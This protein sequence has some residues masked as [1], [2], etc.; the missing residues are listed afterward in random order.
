MYTSDLKEIIVDIKLLFENYLLRCS[1]YESF[2]KDLA[3]R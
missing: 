1:A 3:H 2:G